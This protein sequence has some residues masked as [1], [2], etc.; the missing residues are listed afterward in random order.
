MKE[1]KKRTLNEYRQTKDSVYNNPKKGKKSNR[2]NSHKKTEDATTVRAPWNN[3]KPNK[4]SKVS[5]IKERRRIEY[6]KAIEKAI[7]RGVFIGFML[8]T[9]VGV[10]LGIAFLTFTGQ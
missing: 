6:E 2:K 3:G 8:G 5:R 9:L 1:P 7:L 10:M 4:K